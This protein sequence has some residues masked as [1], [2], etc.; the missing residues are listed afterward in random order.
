MKKYISIILTA[1]LLCSCAKGGAEVTESITSPIE[2]T[3]IT[4]ADKPAQ[5][6]TTAA[7]SETTAAE[8]E[9]TVSET[10]EP[11][12]KHGLY[13][14][15]KRVQ[16]YMEQLAKLDKFRET[17][18]YAADC[19]IC[20]MDSDGT[21]EVVFQIA[22]HISLSAVFSVDEEGAFMA[23]PAGGTVFTE[24]DVS[25]SYYGDTPESFILLGQDQY[26][27]ECW[28]GGSVAGEGGVIKLNLHGRQLS[29][30]YVGQY[31]YGSK[32]YTYRGFEN[33]EQYNDYIRTFF[34]NLEPQ[35]KYM[36]YRDFR[37]LKN[38]VSENHVTV[39]LED[40]YNDRDKLAK[41]EEQLDDSVSFDVEFK[42]VYECTEY[43]D[44]VWAYTYDYDYA[45][46][47]TKNGTSKEYT[48]TYYPNG[49][50]KTQATR[51]GGYTEYD[52]E[53]NIVDD[54]IKLTYDEKGRVKTRTDYGVTEYF[55]KGDTDEVIKTVCTYN[56][57][58]TITILYENGLEV[59]RE[60][61]DPDYEDWYPK[62]IA[63]TEYT[64]EGLVSKEE[65]FDHNGNL[66]RRITYDYDSENRL[67][68]EESLTTEF[69]WD[70]SDRC[71]DYNYSYSYDKEGRLLQET[72]ILGTY[73]G[74]I[75][76]WEYVYDKYGNLIEEI[77]TNSDH[78]EMVGYSKGT[79]TTTYR[80][81]FDL[82]GNVIETVTTSS[83][84]Q[85]DVTKYRAVR[86]IA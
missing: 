57:N 70:E 7:S 49:K 42:P 43:S 53:G 69:Y 40:Y 16:S 21:P 25:Y 80:H 61:L 55:Y 4:E 23:E 68:C 1:M 76:T 58:T 73:N 59:S 46:N 30:E 3:V 83:D 29:S 18:P 52:E 81:K 26:F 85:E 86:V 31:S 47:I 77:N 66:A 28:V 10:E 67:I 36:P 51:G 45:G 8:T 5:T 35:W 22:A 34:G 72:H 79:F 75:L 6:E 14:Y 2:T 41:L 48:Y 50:I 56:G 33:E 15:D 17:L 38:P 44:D 78:N 64:S 11:I 62:R 9:N 20:D 19:L 32:S 71:N 63:L 12:N 24:G 13:S 65:Y 39:L 74:D 84:G 60:W 82:A 37:G 54:D 27:A